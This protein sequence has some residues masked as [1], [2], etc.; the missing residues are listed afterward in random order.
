MQTPAIFSNAGYFWP[1]DLR[2]VLLV[3]DGKLGY[4]RPGIQGITGYIRVY[5]GMQGFRKDTKRH[6]VRNQSTSSIST[7]L[8][9]YYRAYIVLHIPIQYYIPL[10]RTIHVFTVLHTPTQHYT[11]LYSTIHPYAALY[12]TIQHYTVLQTP[13]Q[14]H[15]VLHTSM[16]STI[17]HY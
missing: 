17:Q 4:A 10:H 11:P 8:E 1:R 15:T 7:N 5:R 13:I 16:Y 9:V 2:I 3:H 12:N 6:L 14:H